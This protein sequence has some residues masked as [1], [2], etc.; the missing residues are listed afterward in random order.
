MGDQRKEIK[1]AIL[2]ALAELADDPFLKHG[3][4]RNARS[5]DFKRKLDRTTQ[6]ITIEFQNGPRDNPNAAAVIHP[7]L[8]VNV[9]DINAL[10]V[11]MTG[12]DAQSVPPNSWTLNQPIEFTS[13]K[14]IGARWFIYQR[15]SVSVAINNFISF[16]DTWVFPFLDEY[17][18][19]NDVVRMYRDGDTKVLS[20]L[21]HALRVIASMI[22][23][24]DFA[25]A[26]QTLSKHFGR[27]GPRRRLACVFDFVEKRSELARTH[28]DLITG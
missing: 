7:W 11:E 6:K 3:F 2:Q 1:D 8:G 27:P 21:T 12:N 22:L 20:D 4:R 16:C 28:N 9:L 25:G 19:A 18:D 14:G 5:L 23:V 13:P 26:Q 24:G 17:R 15:D 10:A